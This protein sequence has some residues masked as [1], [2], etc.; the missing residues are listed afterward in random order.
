MW[1]RIAAGEVVS[2]R[3]FSAFRFVVMVV[4]ASFSGVDCY[5]V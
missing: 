1:R 5:G 4:T 3:A 2:R